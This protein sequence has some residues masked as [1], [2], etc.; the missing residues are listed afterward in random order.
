MI[1]V[2]SFPWIL[3]LSMDLENDSAVIPHYY[4]SS[5]ASGGA[6]LRSS[7]F[8]VIGTVYRQR[9]DERARNYENRRVLSGSSAALADDLA[10]DLSP[11]LN[12]RETFVKAVDRHTLYLG[13]SRIYIV[14]LEVNLPDGRLLF[15]LNTA[16]FRPARDRNKSADRFRRGFSN[17][18]RVPNIGDRDSHDTPGSVPAKYQIYR[19]MKC[20]T[21]SPRAR[22]RACQS[23]SLL[24][25]LRPIRRRDKRA[26][27][28]RWGKLICDRNLRAITPA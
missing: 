3:D 19:L 17:L 15:T 27:L 6:R 23:F 7:R 10:D 13:I 28:S 4:Y 5:S 26:D 1:F 8:P 16:P 18:S 9:E 21:F 25:N 14:I 24:F 11:G 20:T 2:S 22:A 12:W